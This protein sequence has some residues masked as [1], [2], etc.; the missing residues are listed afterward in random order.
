[1]GRPD[2]RGINN[3]RI[4][5]CILVKGDVAK[6]TQGVMKIFVG[7][8]V[9]FVFFL[10]LAIKRCPHVLTMKLYIFDRKP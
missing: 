10:L 5:K 3:Q 4:P 8:H 1:M 6:Y 9:F 7:S 2:K